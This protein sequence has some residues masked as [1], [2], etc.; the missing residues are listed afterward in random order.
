MRKD[1]A[2]G[3]FWTKPFMS[4][5]P[6]GAVIEQRAVFQRERHTPP[7]QRLGS[8]KA[9]TVTSSAVEHN[10]LNFSTFSSTVPIIIDFIKSDTT[11][12]GNA[13]W[14]QFIW[15]WRDTELSS[16]SF[17]TPFRFF[18]IYL[19]IYC[20]LL[21]RATPAA[22]GSSQP[23]SN[24]SSSASDLHHSHSKAGLKPCLWPTPQLIAMAGP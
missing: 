5:C 2:L 13:K 11:V 20:I 6:Q 18:Y 17:I 24:Q 3:C 9:L 8:R 10:G 14:T 4:H 16:W 7:Q 15:I 1:E 19:F 12:Y 23:L 21:F 22:N